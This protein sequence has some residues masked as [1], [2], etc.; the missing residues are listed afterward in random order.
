MTVTT[1]SLQFELSVNWAETSELTAILTSDSE[2]YEQ[3]FSDDKS[4]FTLLFDSLT[5]DTD[6]HLEITDGTTV[7]LSED[8]RTATPQ[9]INIAHETVSPDSISLVF[10]GS[11]L[12]DIYTVYLDDIACGNV[13]A[14]SV[15]IA[16]EELTPETSY[17]VTVKNKVGDVVFDKTYLTPAYEIVVTETASEISMTQIYVELNVEH[18]SDTLTAAI[19]GQS[20]ALTD[21]VNVIRVTGLL[22]GTE[23]TLEVSD[24]NEVYL[25]RTYITDSY[26]QM[27][28]PAETVL[29]ESIELK[30]DSEELTASS[31]TVMLDGNEYGILSAADTDILLSGLTPETSYRV[32]I[33][34]GSGNT[35][36]GKTYLTPAYEVVVTE[37]ASEIS[38][39]Q[40]YVELNVEH[41]SDTL[42]AA[43]AG[44]SQA[45]TDGV[46]V[47]RVTGL[48]PG[49]E[50]T[51]EV[52]DE[53]EVYLTRTYITDSYVQMLFPAE[54]VLPES[55]ELKFDSEELTAS[56]YT[57]MLDGNEYGILSA[58]DTDILLSG[59]TP[60]TSYR[61]TIE[62]GSG[63]TVFG[64]TYLT[65]AYE[66]VVT[67]TASEISMTRIYVELNVEHASDTLTAKIGR[68]SR[69]LHDGKNTIEITGLN[70]DT[71]Y[72][73]E[74][75]DGETVCFAKTY[76][77]L[78]YEQK[79]FPV[80]TVLSESIELQFTPE[81]LTADSYIIKLNGEE[82]GVLS[83][84]QTVLLFE[85][86]TPE[87]DYRVTI[88]DDIGNTVFDKTYITVPDV[89]ITEISS[90]I[91]MTKLR[92]ELYVENM[93]N[94]LTVTYGG[95]SQTLQNGT[96][97]IE[98]SGLSPGTVYAVRVTDG[99]TEYFFQ[100]YRTA[101][102]VQT[103]FPVEQYVGIDTIILQ[104]D[105][106]TISE[107]GY[108]VYVNNELYGVLNSSNFSIVLENLTPNT[109][110]H[111]EVLDSNEDIMLEDYYLTPYLIADVA[112]I[113]CA[114]TYISLTLFIQS[115]QGQADVSLRSE[116][117]EYYNKIANPENSGEFI[118]ENL[119]PLTD[120]T[121][122]ITDD[123]GVVYYE[124][125]L[126]TE[127]SYSLV[128][129]SG[130][131]I[132][133]DFPAWQFDG[134]EGVEVVLNDSTSQGMF[135]GGEITLSDLTPLT[136]YEITVYVSGVIYWQKTFTTP[137]IIVD[138]AEPIVGSNTMNVIFSVQNPQNETLRA[139]TFMGDIEQQSFTFNQSE[140]TAT[141]DT[142]ENGLYYVRLIR[143]SDGLILWQKQIPTAYSFVYIP[144]SLLTETED[145]DELWEINGQYIDGIQIEIHE[146][147]QYFVLSEIRLDCIAQDG[148][149]LT[150]TAQPDGNINYYY[151]MM[152]EITLD[153]VYELRIYRNV[154]GV[155]YL[156]ESLYWKCLKLLP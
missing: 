5:P 86:L 56:S 115:Q 26:V 101:N 151:L 70:I 74:V 38:M 125:V 10:D 131:E 124:D 60:E 67:E 71:E 65:P 103:L 54:T 88:E 106:A 108:T 21:G 66:V 155:D 2:Q 120:Y 58:A 84:T 51:L 104:F 145:G 150:L 31:Y 57:V 76:R 80:E 27:L 92:V 148:S 89:S 128:S 68:L 49:T 144:N 72:T 41:A 64:K 46:N 113:T 90:E 3:T 142:I 77:T 32:T 75:S 12:T 127:L 156:I 14:D 116:S 55:I 95:N 135:F 105:E 93:I 98:L 126:R 30:F 119:T 94:P 149:N 18:A 1:H 81:E 114:P 130:T 13:S 129:I 69:S 112:S 62:D 110:Y 107:D 137:D 39:T 19:A 6:Y 91:S 7:F 42:T 24:E 61:V 85:G 152:E 146:D 15:E 143:E 36:F 9:L 96:N 59:L 100:T 16:W 25:T 132:T 44:Q 99:T 11:G 121:L 139:A 63:N 117:G 138:R 154:D 23:Y 111:I 35:V 78:A 37:T 20:Q 97:I 40:I 123:R 53:N 50:Y 22:P 133:L 45:L 136:E 17:R 109:T 87:T 83:A 122:T 8:C 147:T 47:I 153:T 28:F 33:E 140:F 34:D 134:L 118:F 52:S 79:L 4:S 82:T 73:L 29:P 48:L 141:F 43:I 102:Y